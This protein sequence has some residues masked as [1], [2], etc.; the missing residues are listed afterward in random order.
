ML[1]RSKAEV[2]AAVRDDRLPGLSALSGPWS[3]MTASQARLAYNYALAAIET[4][5]AEEGE[6]RVRD[7]IRSPAS[8][9]AAAGRI[10]ESLKR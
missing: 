6:D 10:V 3:G 2:R 4:L 9:A 8:L 7:L 1:F 5:I